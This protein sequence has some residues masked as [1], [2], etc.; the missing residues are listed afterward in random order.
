MSSMIVRWAIRAPLRIYSAVLL[1]VIATA[2]MIPSIQVDTDPEN[3]LPIDNK[4]RLFHNGV[5]QRF[6]MH[7]AI[8][9]GAL[10]ENGIATPDSLNALLQLTEDILSIEGVIDQDLMAIS[11]SDNITQEESGSIRFEWLQQQPLKS[12]SEAQNLR[13]AIKR[14]PL[15]D[16]T[17]MSADGI[18]AAIYVPITDKDQSYRIAEEIRQKIAR[19][20]G[21]D[22]YHITGLP[23]AEDQF[24]VEMFI[25]M[26][27]SAPLAGLMIFAVMWW[28]FRNLQLIVAPMLVA[29]ATVIIT[30]GLLIGM[31]FTVHIMSS[32]IAIFLMPIAVVD[33]VHILSEFADR[34]KAGKQAS[35]TVKEVLEH[36]FVPMLFTSITST[37]GFL[38][39]LLTP[40]PPVQIFGAFVGF[41]IMLAFLIT[42]FLVPA[43][44]SRMKPDTLLALQHT[45]NSR[46]TAHSGGPFNRV[47]AALGGISTRHAKPILVIFSLLLCIAAV[48]VIQIQINDNPIN[49]FKADHEIRIADQQLNKHYAGTYNAYL[50]LDSQPDKTDPKQFV[51]P[52]I[53]KLEG[54]NIDTTELI[55]ALEQ[56]PS[57]SDAIAIADDALF[58]MPPSAQPELSRLLQ[59]LEQL[60]AQQKRFLQLDVL[61]W[62]SNL[63][64]YL[65][66]SGITG[67]SN[68]LVD[69]IKTVNRELLSGEA[70][71][72][73][74]PDTANGVAQTLLQF[75]SSHRPS[76]LWHF[77]TPDYRSSLIWLQLS[78]GDNQDMAQVIDLVDSFLETN[79]LPSGLNLNW[80]GKTFINLVWQDAMVSGMLHSLLS[81]F[82]IVFLMMALL[83]R[84]LIYG[85]LAMLPLT[86]TI[87]LIYGLIGWT[88]KDYDM[89][90]A[91]L[92]ALTLGLSVDFAIHFLERARALYQK[93]GSLEKTVSALFQEPARAISR[94]ALVISIGFTPLLL[95][96]LVPY[97]TVG[98]FLASIMIISALVTLL[99]FPALAQ[100]LRKPLV[101]SSFPSK[102]SP[103]NPASAN[104]EQRG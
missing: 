57:I 43:Y 89:P 102:P 17:L 12:I 36:L 65:Q 20:P 47:I 96:P 25:Q 101:Q 103:G 32:M 93:T 16:N 5:K 97:I 9:V 91:V 84:S 29:M 100:V 82:I 39:L 48:G 8:V 24:G 33:S 80:A 72:F 64:D 46:S 104:S 76:D 18:S 67:K 53:T 90:I 38:S 54:L 73:K 87:T 42:I 86:F 62:I 1:L 4:A 21:E 71:D 31:G 56:A 44:I 78:S 50:V 59:Q 55:K 41:G 75:Q 6:A 28:F 85:L 79:P 58:E 95:A 68:S 99:L 77:V 37:V 35:Q 61:Q 70:V 19:L 74:L 13:E 98:V 92:S 26:G 40:I 27:I 69:I 11:R 23:I 52:A 45:C 51:E 81:A 66:E 94:N 30:M 49:W 88:G 7:D 15:L 2:S 63:Q 60:Q 83:F 3:M 10:N 22:Q 34:Y 14:L